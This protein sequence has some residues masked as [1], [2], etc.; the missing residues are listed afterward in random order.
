MVNKGGLILLLGLAI[1]ACESPPTPQLP[2]QHGIIPAP[3]QITVQPGHLSLQSGIQL[4]ADSLFAAQVAWWQQTSSARSLIVAEKKAAIRVVLK[5][6]RE[7][8]SSEEAYRLVIEEGAV[9]LEASHPKGMSRAL[10]SLE[11]L[12]QLNQ[13]QGVF[14][15]PLLAIDDEPQFAH[16]GL[17]LDCSRHFFSPEVI[18]KYLHLMALFKMNT[19]HWHLTEDQGWRLPIAKYPR[20]NSISA[21]RYHGDSA[22]GGFYTREQIHHLVQYAAARGI[23]IIPEIELPGHSQAAIAA[24]PQ[25]SCTGEAVPVANDWGVF[26]EIYCAGNDSVF[27]FLEEVLLEV[28]E[29]FPSEKIHIGGDEAPKTRWQACAKCQRRMA[30]EGLASEEE[31][32]SYFIQRIQSFLQAH[33]RT[34]IGWDE[35]LEGGLAEGAIVQSWRGMEGGK[36]A[37]Q[38]GH[39]AVMSPTSHAY[40]DYD[41]SAINLEKVYTFD[42]IPEGLS[43]EEASLILGGECNMWTEHVPDEAALDAKVFPRLLAMTEVLWTYPKER[44]FAEFVERVQP[45]YPLLDAMKVAYGEEAIPFT[46]QMQLKDQQAFLALTPYA[47][48]ISLKFSQE[49]AQ[50]AMSQAYQAPIPIEQSGVYQVVAEKNGKPY[51]AP[52]AIAVVHHQAIGAQVTYDNAYSPWYTAGGDYGL[53]DGLLGSLNFRDGAWQGFWGEDAQLQIAFDSPRDIELVRIHFYQYIN[54]WIVIPPRMRVETSTDGVQWQLMGTAESHWPVEDREK[55]IRSLRIEKST[56]QVRYLR[57][58]V[59][60][61]GPLPHWHEAAG[62]DSWIFMDEIEVQ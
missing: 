18:E 31:L 16:R 9:L 23:E 44:D 55:V 58:L 33:G 42:P 57:I 47:D 54:S 36:E 38:H 24:Y 28:M 7:V 10:A 30:E 34:I 21:Y 56:E 14:Y 32:Q 15:L 6:S 26:K 1:G 3:Q 8:A 17:L 13:Q 61:L 12:L 37:V 20:L 53:V 62:M 27:T 43:A 22:Y 11:Q 46:Y 52:K 51:G 4:E 19:L 2:L 29:L 50:Q 25:L 39:Q 59:E 41:L 48:N 5:H 45:F 49:V 40:F 60:Q 35:I